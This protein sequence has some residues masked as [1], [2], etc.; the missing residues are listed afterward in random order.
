MLRATRVVGLIVGGLLLLG[1]GRAS[2]QD[3]PQW[4]GPNRDAKATGFKAPAT[5]PKELTKKWSVTL[6]NGV[7]TPA[8]AGGKL[9]VFTRQDDNEVVRYLDA[10]SG[11]ELWKDEYPAKAPTGGAGNFPGPRSSPTVSDGKVVTLGVEGTLTCY[12]VNSGRQLWRKEG[13]DDFGGSLP[14]FFPASSPIV[15]DGLCIAQLGGQDEVGIVAFDLASGEEKWR[16]PGY[17]PAYG[18][19]ALMNV[20]G[21]NLVI[22]PTE[23]KMVALGTADGKQVWEIPTR[24]VATTRPRR[25]SGDTLILAI[26]QGMS[27]IKLEQDGQVKEEKFEQPENSVVQHAG[28]QGR[29]V[30]GLSNG[31]IVLH[32]HVRKRRRGRRFGWRRKEKA[33]GQENQA[34]RAE[35]ASVPRGSSSSCSSKRVTSPGRARVVDAAKASDAAKVVVRVAVGLAVDGVVVGA[36]AVAATARSSTPARCC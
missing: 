33:A 27:A 29:C 13:K 3:W 35:G 17:S 23:K 32:Q 8:L 19:P 34:A 25:L 15:V 21:T 4:R 9:F 5:W 28:A 16:R 18:S 10:A 7:A 14:M 11:D 20:G 2:G 22:A 36:A 6:G 1:G 31:P 30:V 12:D 24:K 26:R